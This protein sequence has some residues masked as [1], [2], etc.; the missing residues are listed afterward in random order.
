MSKLKKNFI[1]IFSKTKKDEVLKEEIR[2]WK[3]R[4]E[5]YR[6]KYYEKD[7]NEQE[8][9]DLIAE[10]QVLKTELKGQ[11]EQVVLKQKVLESLGKQVRMLTTALND[12]EILNP[13]IKRIDK[14][15]EL[16]I[17]HTDGAVGF[18]LCN[19]LETVV[20]GYSFARIP[21]NI[22]VKVPDNYMLQVSLRS[23]TPERYGL[24]IPHGVGIIDQDYYGPEDEILLLVYNITDAAIRI[25]KGTRLAQA[26]FVKIGN[27]EWNEIDEIESE[28]RSGFG[29]TG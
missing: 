3:E 22:I 21:V 11:K 27:V 20:K 26:I 1:S 16:P 28:N 15:L 17:Y 4:Y 14:E 13:D 25:S 23:S 8:T 9:E 24:I 6:D 12:Q 2:K 7:I 10:N 29:S 5:L 18:D 19:R